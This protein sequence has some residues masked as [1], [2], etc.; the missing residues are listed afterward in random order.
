MSNGGVALT[1]LVSAALGEAR[2]QIVDYMNS[3]MQDT[4]E[5]VRRGTPVFSY[6]TGLVVDQATVIYAG[7]A[8]VSLSS[9]GAPTLV[10]DE[11]Q[12]WDSA[13]VKLPPG[14]AKVKIDDTVTLISVVDPTVVGRKFRVTA[15]VAGGLVPD[16]QTLDSVGAAPSATNPKA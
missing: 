9:G 1:G 7:P 4:V 6:S 3:I 8:K 10:G 14:A 15:V 12:F 11:L 5:V 16:G 13:K 2:N